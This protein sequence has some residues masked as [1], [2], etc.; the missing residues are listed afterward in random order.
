MNRTRFLQ[1][2]LVAPLL[3]AVSALAAPIFIS[4]EVA[5]DGRVTFRVEA[6]RAQ[7]V[8]VAGLRGRPPQPMSKGA[9][10]I[11]TVTVGPLA[12]DLYG[13]T[14]DIDGAPVT[15]R[16][17]RRMKD[18]FTQESLLEVPGPGSLFTQQPVP[19]GVVHRHVVP[20][21][22]RGGEVALEVYTPPGFDPKKAYP[23]LYLLHG[24]GDEENAWRVAGR[25][26]FIADNLLA[27]GKA[28]PM[29]IVLTNGHPV[30]VPLLQAVENYDQRNL[31]AME[32]ELF[33]VVMPL[34]ESTYAV[35]RDAAGRAIAGL[36]MGGYHA[37]GIGLNRAGEFGAVAG[38]SS[39]VEHAPFDRQ[40]ARL[41][42]AEREHRPLPAFVWIGC[43]RDDFLIEPNRALVAWLRSA[44]LD[45]EW[46]ETDGAHEWTVWRDY[47]GGF[48]PRLFR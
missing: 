30:P 46:R 5:P 14:I 44:G 6:P 17:N 19:H 13:Y 47:L 35:R 25:A 23:V 22:V 43:G 2:A 21:S 10:G 42:V 37:L 45:F 24:F 39:G 4:P 31:E 29:V 36:S 15:D 12:P 33:S 3:V 16:R 28:V 20:S 41:L 26:H 40:F 27:Q 9:D 34:V 8:A 38:F 48:L 18:W 32:R 11:W 7:A 1:R